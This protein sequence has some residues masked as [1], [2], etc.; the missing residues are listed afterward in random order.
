MT[1]GLLDHYWEGSRASEPG[2]HPPH[3]FSSPYYF[4]IFTVSGADSLS[5]AVL[6]SW[7]LSSRR[8]SLASSRSE[9]PFAAHAIFSSLPGNSWCS[10][11][12]ELR[13]RGCLGEQKRLLASLKRKVCC[14]CAVAPQLIWCGTTWR[15]AWRDNF[16]TLMPSALLSAAVT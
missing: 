12:K 2:V 13:R 10:P 6:Y 4:S 3:L 16:A 11:S 15:K 9:K 14:F 5:P 7:R 1:S 8:D